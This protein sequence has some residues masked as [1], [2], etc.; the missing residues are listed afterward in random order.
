MAYFTIPAVL[1]LLGGCRPQHKRTSAFSPKGLYIETFAVSPFGVNADYLTDSL[2]FR[3]K[4]GTW[5][6]EHEDFLYTYR[7]GNVRV[8]KLRYG[9][10]NCRVVTLPN[11]LQTVSCDTQTVERKVY[12]LLALQKDHVFE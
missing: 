6:A 11:G 1:L 7:N 2:T 8:V 12:S 9:Q 3:Q 5:D 4:I 10:A